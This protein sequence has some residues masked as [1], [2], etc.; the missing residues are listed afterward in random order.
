MEREREREREGGR[1]GGREEENREREKV[2]LRNW[3]MLSWELAS[4]CYLLSPVILM[5]V[6]LTV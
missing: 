2:I 4:A 6:I 3:L 1:R 5:I